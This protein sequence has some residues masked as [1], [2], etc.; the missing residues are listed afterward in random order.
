MGDD[1]RLGPLLSAD[2]MRA[3]LARRDNILVHVDR[4]IAQHGEDAVLAFP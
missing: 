4:L 3:I 1:K 2:A